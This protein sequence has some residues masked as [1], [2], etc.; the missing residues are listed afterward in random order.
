MHFDEESVGFV[1]LLKIVN[2]KLNCVRLKV[3]P[4]VKD[5]QFRTISLFAPRIVSMRFEKKIWS[6][7]SRRRYGNMID[8][9]LRAYSNYLEYHTRHDYSKKIAKFSIFLMLSFVCFVFR[10]GMW[11]GVQVNPPSLLPRTHSCR[12]CREFLKILL[13]GPWGS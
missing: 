13:W 12:S 2:F 9:C 1:L 5:S 10:E 4:L 6:E 8:L 11:N 7:H 3:L